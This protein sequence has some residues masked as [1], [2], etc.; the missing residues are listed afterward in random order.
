MDCGKIYIPINE[1]ERLA[2]LSKHLTDKRVLF[3]CRFEANEWVLTTSQ[4]C[5]ESTASKSNPTD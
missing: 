5:A 2:Q 4:D 3:T 1:V